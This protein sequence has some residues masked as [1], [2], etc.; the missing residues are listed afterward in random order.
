MSRG[1]ISQE[2]V[3]SLLF[4][5]LARMG[6]QIAARKAKQGFELLALI[7]QYGGYIFFIASGCRTINTF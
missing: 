1:K 5:V 3:K 6:F 7:I 4:K 2:N